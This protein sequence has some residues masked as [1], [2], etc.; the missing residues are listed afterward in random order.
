MSLSRRPPPLPRRRERTTFFSA[1]GAC[2]PSGRGR[3]KPLGLNHHAGHLTD[4]ADR[5]RA[6]RCLDN[7]T[8]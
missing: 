3:S 4:S 6:K 1:R 2:L 7:R 8:I 5:A